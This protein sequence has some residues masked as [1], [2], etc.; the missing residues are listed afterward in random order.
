MPDI[1]DDAI[2][3]A[4][5]VLLRQYASEYQA[6]H[7]TWHD[8]EHAASEI[9][10]AAA[11]FMAEAVAAKIK[12]HGVKYF[13]HMRSARVRFDIAARIAA[14]AFDTKEDRIRMIA[15][16][17]ESGNYIACSLPED[18]GPREDGDDD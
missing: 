16:A 8:F 4:A 18:A 10:Q 12:A 9:L 13:G 1:P 7:L 6:D 5:E 14:G 2:K 11:P 3:A 15:E 17:L